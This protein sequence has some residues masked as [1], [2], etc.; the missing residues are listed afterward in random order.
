MLAKCRIETYS[1]VGVLQARSLHISVN[2]VQEGTKLCLTRL[3]LIC[4]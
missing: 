1:G 4:V 2:L 3:S